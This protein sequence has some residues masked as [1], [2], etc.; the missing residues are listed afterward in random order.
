[1]TPVWTLVLT[2]NGLEDTRKC[3][4]SLESQAA[5]GHPILVVDNGSTDGT[6]EAVGRE[7][8]WAKRF[9]VEK[10]HGP[11]VGGPHLRSR[12]PQNS[13]HPRSQSSILGSVPEHRSGCS[14]PVTPGAW[15]ARVE[16]A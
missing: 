6:I 15:L 8:P 10:N 4:R 3:L 14:A 5:A 9:R 2:Y 12:A 13:S 16:E 11:S 1:M 7:F